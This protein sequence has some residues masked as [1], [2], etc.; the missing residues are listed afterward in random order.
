MA[1]RLLS[2]IDIGPYRLTNRMVMAPMT[3]SRAGVGDAPEAM[4]TLYYR[5]RAS[6]G[7]I[8]SEGTIIS[9]QA[10]GFADT[11]GL[12]TAEQV[13]GWRAVTTA[14]HD[15]GGRIFA[16]L[17]H[18]GRQSHTDLQPD[19]RPPVGPSSVPAIGKCRTGGGLKDFSVPRALG[20]EE[21]ADIVE[22]YRRAAA[23]ARAAGFDG[24]ELHGAN[25]YLIDQFLQDGANRRTDRYGG[26]LANRSRFLVEVLE[27]LVDVWGAERVGVRLSPCNTHG[28]ISDSVPWALH[29]HVVRTLAGRGLA[30]LHVTEPRTLPGGH[31]REGEEVHAAPRL[32]PLFDGPYIAAGGFDRDSAESLLDAGHADMVA[33]GRA[34]LA[35]PDL[36]DRFARDLPLNAYDR[37]TFYTPGEK[38]YVDYPSWADDR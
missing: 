34:F 8:V 13:E 33:F 29:A 23:N 7:L 30:Y 4:N 26:P 5:Q 1:L 32:R 2:P 25:G 36:P 37:D 17:W 10:R 35:N 14:V 11:P 18:V 22:D 9:P 31:V 21:I 16:Q 12:F 3:R 20:I 38:G 19:G 27:A 15:E 6:A 28:E 24:V